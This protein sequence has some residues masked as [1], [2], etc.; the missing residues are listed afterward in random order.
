MPRWEAFLTGEQ[1]ALESAAL[2]FCRQP[3][4]IVR[5]GERYCLVVDEWD[6]LQD[7]NEVEDRARARL[8]T[9]NGLLSLKIPSFRPLAFGYLAETDEDGRKFV[10]VKAAFTSSSELS[11]KISGP[12]GP[13]IDPDT[14]QALI[15]AA[16]QSGSTRD[17]LRLWHT[18]PHN[19]VELYKIYEIIS[20]DAG[21]D[22][23][24]VSRGWATT[25]ELRS[26]TA[27]ANRRELSGDD[28]RH[29]SDEGRPFKGEPMR[30]AD[31]ESLIRR[32]LSSYVMSKL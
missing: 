7:S 1:A 18:R 27:T 6:E 26:F 19:W 5:S 30:V 28:A 16:Q 8:E 24:I 20:D 13:A 11:V 21:G 23:G 22:K 25:A 2:V 9:I 12:A 15:A 4:A 14:A 3:L 32:V 10:L 29:G 31:A 17:A